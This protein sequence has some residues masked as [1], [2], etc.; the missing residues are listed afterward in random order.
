MLQEWFRDTEIVYVK[1]GMV[2]EFR[3]DF[4]LLKCRTVND[5]HHA[6]DAY[7]NIVVGN[8][9]HERFTKTGSPLTA[10]T[11]FRSKRSSKSSRGTARPATGTGR[12]ILHA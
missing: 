8:V 10:V 2:S 6:K 11:M 12:R 3:Q 4:D 1:A 7:L 9:Y 5:L